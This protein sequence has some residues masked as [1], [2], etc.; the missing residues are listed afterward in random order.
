MGEDVHRDQERS[1]DQHV[2]S[3][4]WMWGWGKLLQPVYSW[5]GVGGG[6]VGQATASA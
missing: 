2:Y 1:I 6:W 3:V 4:R 5:V